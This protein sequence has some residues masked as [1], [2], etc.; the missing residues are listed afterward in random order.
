MRFDTWFKDF[1][2]VYSKDPQLDQVA[3]KQII[4]DAIQD[5]DQKERAKKMMQSFPGDSLRD[6]GAKLD[7]LFDSRSRQEWEELAKNAKQVTT[8]TTFAFAHRCKNLF[9]F[10]AI[11]EGGREKIKSKAF[12]ESLLDA[13]LDGLLED[14]LRR[15]LYYKG[16]QTLDEALEKIR[17]TR[18]NDATIRN[19]TEKR[20]GDTWNRRVATLSWNQ[21]NT[22]QRSRTVGQGQG[23]YWL[24]IPPKKKRLDKK[25]LIFKNVAD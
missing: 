4:I 10:L 19:I 8:E 12:Q 24:S 23:Q 6:F 1:L 11:D 25:R 22:G 14:R 7:M 2:T 16:V 21:L 18:S 13:F 17:I 9:E 5:E 20:R 15:K 3:G